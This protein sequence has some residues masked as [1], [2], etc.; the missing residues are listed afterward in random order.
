MNQG[1]ILMGVDGAEATHIVNA[2]ADWTDRDDEPRP[3]STDTESGYYLSLKPPYQAKNGP[4]DDLTE[5]MMIK[6][7]TPAMYFGSGSGLC[8]TRRR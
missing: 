2:I 4:I 3:G 6:G 1:L 7:I 8:A 5:L